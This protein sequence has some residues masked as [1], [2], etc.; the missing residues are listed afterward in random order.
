MTYNIVTVRMN[1]L[2]LSP[3]LSIYRGL[4]LTRISSIIDRSSKIATL[5]PRMMALSLIIISCSIGPIECRRDK[6]TIARFFILRRRRNSS[7]CI[8]IK[9]IVQES[10]G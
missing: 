7:A 1:G 8:V 4:L 6:S 10:S 5:E 9:F 2:E 3:I